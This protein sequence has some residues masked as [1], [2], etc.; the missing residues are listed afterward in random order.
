VAVA[1]PT[2]PHII[3]VNYSVVD[4]AVII[5]TSPY[6]VLGTYGRDATMAFEIDQFDYDYRRGW[7][8]VARGRAET[9]TD[10][11]ELRH[12]RSVWEP[13]P[14]ASGLRNLFL[15]LPWQELSGRQ[16]GAGWDP[17]R[18]TPVFRAI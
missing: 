9:V 5:S 6:S 12:I 2:G 13:T 1:T 4:S 17:R 8:V 16:L 10:P 7:S 18:E 11:E 14:W 3:P 15:R